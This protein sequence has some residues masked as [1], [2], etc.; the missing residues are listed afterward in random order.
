MPCMTVKRAFAVMH[1]RVSRGFYRSGAERAGEGGVLWF[2]FSLNR[3]RVS[4]A[5][6]GVDDILGYLGQLTPALAA[7]DWQLCQ[8]LAVRGRGVD[9]VCRVR[10]WDGAISE[11]VPA[12]GLSAVDVIAAAVPVPGQNA[13]EVSYAA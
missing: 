8:I 10:W 6:S 13:V 3:W 7:R 4:L 2:E 9:A 12:L 5:A 1:R 11:R